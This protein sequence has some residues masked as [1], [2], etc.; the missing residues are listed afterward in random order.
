MTS[1]K[2]RTSLGISAAKGKG[3]EDHAVAAALIEL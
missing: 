1:S 3:L 2:G